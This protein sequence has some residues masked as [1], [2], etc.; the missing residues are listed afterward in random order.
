MDS[1]VFKNLK[2]QIFPFFPIIFQLYGMIC[3]RKNLRLNI[4]THKKFF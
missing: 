1:S 3:G 2:F 4:H